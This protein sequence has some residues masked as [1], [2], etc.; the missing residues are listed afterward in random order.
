M[1]DRG[2]VDGCSCGCLGGELIVSLGD[3]FLAHDPAEMFLARRY[4]SL[5]CGAL[6]GL[7]LGRR[8]A[9]PGLLAGRSRGVVSGAPRCD[10]PRYLGPRYLGGRSLR[11]SRA[12]ACALGTAVCGGFGVW[13]RPAGC[14]I[15]A[16]GRGLSRWRH[17]GGFH[18][19]AALLSDNP[20]IAATMI[21]GDVPYFWL[22]ADADPPN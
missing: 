15:A 17:L 18:A 6:H 3:A 14:G 7:G 19:L 21:P 16:R 12:L 20:E 10:G 22:G 4:G 5:A 9:Y 13:D 8:R 1:A 2:V 11:G